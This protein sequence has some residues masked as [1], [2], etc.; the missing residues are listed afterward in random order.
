MTI[1]MIYFSIYI[2]DGVYN[3]Q[4]R[5]RNLFSSSSLAFVQ[6]IYEAFFCLTLT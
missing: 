4:F 2:F 6:A 3:K 1:E 5:K